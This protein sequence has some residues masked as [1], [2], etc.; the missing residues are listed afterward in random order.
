MT[1]LHSTEVNAVSTTLTVAS[2]MLTSTQDTVHAEILAMTIAD[3]R[4]SRNIG[5]LKIWRFDAK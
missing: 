2:D 5:E 4:I 1:T 3:Y